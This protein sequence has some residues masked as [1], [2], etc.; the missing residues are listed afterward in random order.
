M[1]KNEKIVI[2]GNEFY[3]VDLDC[4][5]KKKLSRKT[6]KLPKQELPDIK[7]GR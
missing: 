2:K 4:I 1:K 7:K 5:E 6:G 3:V